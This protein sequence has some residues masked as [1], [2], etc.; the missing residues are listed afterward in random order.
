MEK[1]TDSDPEEDSGALDCDT[2][3]RE[4]VP[5]VLVLGICGAD[6]LGVSIRGS[7]DLL[8]SAGSLTSDAGTAKRWALAAPGK[9]NREL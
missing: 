7:T 8:T 4:A 5:L 3:T 2:G 1:E 6:A 9:S